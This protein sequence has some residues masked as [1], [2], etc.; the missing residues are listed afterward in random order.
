MLSWCFFCSLFC[1]IKACLSFYTF[2]ISLVRTLPSCYLECTLA[3][4][5]VKTTGV[6]LKS[7]SGGAGAECVSALQINEAKGQLK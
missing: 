2:F 4:K 3:F 7:V 5:G 1:L 6:F